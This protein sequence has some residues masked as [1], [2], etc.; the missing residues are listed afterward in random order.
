VTGTFTNPKS[1]VNLGKFLATPAA[2]LIN[3]LLR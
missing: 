1:K 2:Q 3:G